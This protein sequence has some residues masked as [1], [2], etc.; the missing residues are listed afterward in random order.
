MEV[1]IGAGV[2][3]IFMKASEDLMDMFAVLFHVVRVDEDIIQV[4]E[5]TY[6]EHVGEDVVHEVLKAASALVRQKGIT[7]H[8]KEP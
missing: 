3:V 7:H 8:L 2:Q 6:I 5:D 1:R 4:D